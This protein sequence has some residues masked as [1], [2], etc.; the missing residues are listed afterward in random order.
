MLEIDNFQLHPRIRPIELHRDPQL[1]KKICW[2]R[3]WKHQFKSYSDWHV[4]E[5]GWLHG[6][7]LKEIKRGNG[8]RK[9]SHRCGFHLGKYLQY[10]V[11]H[12]QIIHSRSKKIFDSDTGKYHHESRVASVR[13]SLG[14]AL[15]IN[16]DIFDNTLESYLHW[17]WHKEL[18]REW[19]QC[20]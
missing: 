15:S 10:D 2:T 1:Y 11:D 8:F 4:H 17:N 12:R 5:C 9:R 14:L 19:A 18:Y 13:G 6:Q 16:P 20:R 7:D 3:K